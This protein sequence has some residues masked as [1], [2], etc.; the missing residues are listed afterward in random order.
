MA[1]WGRKRRRRRIGMSNDL[2]G[3][4]P[5]VGDPENH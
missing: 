1:L 3:Y 5:L 2:F 4:W